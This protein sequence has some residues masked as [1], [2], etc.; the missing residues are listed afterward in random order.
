MIWEELVIE[1]FE[2]ETKVLKI[3]TTFLS[4]TLYSILNIIK[5]PFIANFSLMSRCQHNFLP[6]VIK[7]TA[8]MAEWY[9]ASVS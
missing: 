9:G 8:Q 2:P 7:L 1:R 5:I 4:V 3:T 6:V